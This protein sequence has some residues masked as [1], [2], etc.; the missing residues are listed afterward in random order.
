MAK[1]GR[2]ASFLRYGCFGCL[3]VIAIGLVL[4]A[5]VLFSPT[6]HPWYLL[7]VLPFMALIPV[8]AWLVLSGLGLLAYQVLVGYSITGVWAEQTW[9]RIRFR[10][11]PFHIGSRRDRGTMC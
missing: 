6:V 8:P 2:W 1:G 4:G 5:V 7:W 3:G 10:R 9:V 11:Y